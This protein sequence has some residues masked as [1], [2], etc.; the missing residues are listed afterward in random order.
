MLRVIC[1]SHSDFDLEARIEALP[2]LDLDDFTRRKKE[3]KRTPSASSSSHA[4]SHANVHATSHPAPHTTR[5]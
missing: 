2:A 5:K 3:K 1:P 4:A